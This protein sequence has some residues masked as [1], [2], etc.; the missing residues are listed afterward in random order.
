MHPKTSHPQKSV[1]EVPTSHP[2]TL[3]NVNQIHLKQNYVHLQNQ[4]DISLLRQVEED[5]NKIK[6]K[7][8]KRERKWYHAKLEQ[9]IEGYKKHRKSIVGKGSM[10]YI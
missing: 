5:I 3:L 10:I 8:K 1:T 2:N 4:C 6:L 9:A 7:N